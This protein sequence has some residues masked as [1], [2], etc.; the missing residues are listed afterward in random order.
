MNSQ[1]DLKTLSKAVLQKNR[2]LN[3]RLTRGSNRSLFVKL[4]FEVKSITEGIKNMVSDFGKRDPRH[5][6]W[7][8]IREHRAELWIAHRAAMAEIGS[9]FQAKDAGRVLAA[10]QTALD[11]FNSM[12]A[13]WEHRQDVQPDLMEDV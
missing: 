9:G 1:I 2:Q 10:K 7:Q 11:T 6:C 8:W 13:I 5:G 3:T 12:L 4:D